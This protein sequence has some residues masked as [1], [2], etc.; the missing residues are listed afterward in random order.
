N[1]DILKATIEMA[2]A[3]GA[4]VEALRTQWEDVLDGNLNGGLTGTDLLEARFAAANLLGRG[5]EAVQL[6]RQLEAELGP[7][8]V[9]VLVGDPAFIASAARNYAIDELVRPGQ[10]EVV[11]SNRVV[12]EPRS[13]GWVGTTVGQ[14]GVG[15]QGM[16]MTA[17]DRT[18][19]DVYWLQ[20]PTDNYW[21]RD[22][23]GSLI[24]NQDEATARARELISNGA[25][26]KL[27]PLQP[28]YVSPDNGSVAT[29]D[30]T[31]S[32]DGVAIVEPTVLVE[33][34]GVEVGNT[35]VGLQGALT[36]AYTPSGE[37][38]FW[39]Q[40]PTDN[41]LLRNG[42]GDLIRGQGEA[43]QRALELIRS[44]SATRLYSLD[45]SSGSVGNDGNRGTQIDGVTIQ[46]TPSTVQY[47]GVESVGLQGLLMWGREPG[48]QVV[49]WLQGAEQSPGGSRFNYVL[50][51]PDGE[52]IRSQGEAM[53]RARDYITHGLATQLEPL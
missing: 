47:V 42:Q 34:V 19:Q 27:Y 52:L 39:L 3:N 1:I 14:G 4:S 24:A 21:L 5:E 40:G 32:I 12:G 46:G 44:G 28:E 20:G 23:S 38:V 13:I 25:A 35:G 29:T 31:R 6:Y 17:Q 7:P 36:W 22:A 49:F 41:Y 37:R 2:I 9:G 48:G 50:R 16:L 33:Y 26:T 43:Q 53:D 11:D 8:G 45:I 10:T 30:N 15:L 18:G 51:S